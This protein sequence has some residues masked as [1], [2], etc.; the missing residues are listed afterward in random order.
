MGNI[1]TR[2]FWSGWRRWPFIAAVCAAVFW[3]VSYIVLQQSNG[4]IC[5]PGDRAC[6]DW[7][8]HTVGA[9]FY[10]GYLLRAMIVAPLL[11]LFSTKSAFKVWAMVSL[12]VLA[13]FFY[14]LLFVTPIY[15]TYFNKHSMNNGYGVLYLALTLAIVVLVPLGTYLYRRFGAR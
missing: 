1:F 8:L 12:P 11:T 3:G 14:D 6:L 15:G 5:S 2:E 7:W 4:D 10:G 13:Y 9:P